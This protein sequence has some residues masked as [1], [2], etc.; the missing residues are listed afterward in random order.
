MLLVVVGFIVFSTLTQQEK[1][2]YLQY[3]KAKKKFYQYRTNFGLKLPLRLLLVI[4]LNRIAHSAKCI[5]IDQHLS[6][7]STLSP[8]NKEGKTKKRK[9]VDTSTDREKRGWSLGLF[10]GS[11]RARREKKRKENKNVLLY[12][13]RSFTGWL[14]RV[15]MSI[16]VG[17]YKVTI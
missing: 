12:N 11:W 10:Q 17:G 13:S 2:I 14:N 3:G 7:L 8:Q 1:V 5:T 6:W 15:V 16:L 9:T 4:S